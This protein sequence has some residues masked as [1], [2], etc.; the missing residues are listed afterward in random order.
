MSAR[1]ADLAYQAIGGQ[2]AANAVHHEVAA[3]IADPD[4]LHARLLAVLATGEPER[5]RAFC[6]T[7]Q[8]WIEREG[9]HATE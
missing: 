1:V 2:H 7:L 9:R 5:L 3:G 8:K 6:R 4:L